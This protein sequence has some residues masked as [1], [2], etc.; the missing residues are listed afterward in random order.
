[1]GEAPEKNGWPERGLRR[2]SDEE[3]RRR[4]R[5]RTRQRLEKI[6]HG[7]KEETPHPTALRRKSR[8]LAEAGF[9]RCKDQ[10]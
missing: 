7:G 8:A 6:G 2:P 4:R 10:L 5:S 1:M 3:W 9:S